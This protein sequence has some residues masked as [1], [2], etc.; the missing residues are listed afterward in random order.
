[1]R[2]IG[3]KYYS[4]SSGIPTTIREEVVRDPDSIDSVYRLNKLE[5]VVKIEI[6]CQ[7]GILE[8]IET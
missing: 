2:C 4:V 5:S 7:K 3:L 6:M 1:M 8:F